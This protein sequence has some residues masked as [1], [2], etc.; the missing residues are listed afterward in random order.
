ME[1]YHA[2]IIGKSQLTE[3]FNPKNICLK[4]ADYRFLIKKPED[5]INLENIEIGRL[6]LLYDDSQSFKKICKVL[7]KLAMFE[8]RCS[9]EFYYCKPKSEFHFYSIRDFLLLEERDFAGPRG[10]NT[11]IKSMKANKIVNKF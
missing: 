3:K 1:V 4:P 8:K 10:S 11:F 9:V 6:I 5:E 7:G 2:L